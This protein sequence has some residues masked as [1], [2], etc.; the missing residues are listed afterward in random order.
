MPRLVRRI[1]QTQLQKPPPT[2]VRP[3][4]GL[5]QTYNR[6]QDPNKSAAGIAKLRELRVEMDNAMA[7][8][9]SEQ[10]N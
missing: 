4:E 5:T 3:V 2:D 7:I 8:F 9:C 1:K 6:F 10:K